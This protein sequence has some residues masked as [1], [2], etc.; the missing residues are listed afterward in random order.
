MMKELFDNP[1]MT[2]GVN[3]GHC[4]TPRPPTW[5]TSYHGM[6]PCVV[7]ADFEHNVESLRGANLFILPIVD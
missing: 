4:V 2:A 1:C 3:G 6:R 5:H 7:G